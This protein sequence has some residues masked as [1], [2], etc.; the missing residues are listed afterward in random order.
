MPNTTTTSAATVSGL[1]DRLKAGDDTVTADDLM[2]AEADERF[3][4]ARASAA[5]QA[6]VDRAEAERQARIAALRTA[7]AHRFDPA[8]IAKAQAKLT[9]AV[10]AYLDACRT[11]DNEMDAAT[12]ELRG[13]GPLPDGLDVDTP[14][15]GM[16]TDG[17]VEYRRS[18][19]QTTI[20]AIVTE[21]IRARYGRETI[22]LNAPQN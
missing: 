2:R 3:A 20:A 9:A 5:A 13:M 4:Q 8:P 17:T 10:A 6:A 22:N 18:R 7:L 12:E 15:F 16:I 14:R 21:A 19:P 11:F 1:L